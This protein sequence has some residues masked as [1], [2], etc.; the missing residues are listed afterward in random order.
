M[1]IAQSDEEMRLIKKEQ[2]YSM[3][4]LDSLRLCMADIR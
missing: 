4:G 3:D 2:H 1:R